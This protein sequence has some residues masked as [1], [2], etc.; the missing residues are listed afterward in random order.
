[1]LFN[2][3]IFIFLFLPLCLLGF[4]LLQKRQATLAKVWLTCFSLWFYGYFNV[5]YL[6]IMLCS[7][8]GNYGI[9]RM[10]VDTGKNI[11]GNRYIKNIDGLDTG[12]KDTKGKKYARKN[13]I[14]LIT[15]VVLIQ[16]NRKYISYYLIRIK[17]I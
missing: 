13:K 17:G 11:S 5:S 2:S 3:Y 7:I 1:M 6:L 14:I 4:F 8:V 9:H 10:L 12:N 16:S 15:G